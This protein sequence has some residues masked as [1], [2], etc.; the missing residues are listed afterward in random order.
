MYSFLSA[1]QKRWSVVMVM[2]VLAACTTIAPGMHF[3]SSSV[4][5]DQ[6]TQEVIAVNKPVMKAITPQLV[7]FEREQRD[8]QSLQDISQLVRGPTPYNIQGGDIL[9]ITVWDHPELAGTVT[10][11]PIQGVVGSENPGS[12]TPAT[13][14]V[15]DH[16]GIIQYPYAGSLKVAGMTEGQAKNALATKLGR[17]INKPNITLRVESYRSKRVYLDGEVKQPGLQPITDVPMTLTEAVNRAG[18]F[19]PTADQSQVA[20]TRDG[21]TYKVNLV[22]MMERGVNP[23]TI[24]LANGD[25]VRVLSRDE[26][27]VFVSGEVMQPKSLP[28]HN[29]RMTLN[30]ALGETGGINPQTGD[31]RQVYVVRNAADKDAT[32]YHL[33]TRSPAGLSLAEEFELKPK[34]VV[35]VDAAP[36]ATWHRVI[37]LILPAAL[38][39]A[40]SVGAATR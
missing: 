2:P 39:Q 12:A 32:V 20:V 25:V 15:V 16:E 19:L 24:M 10:S 13:G 1:H 9:A 37:S 38:S 26:S 8:K 5:A 3:D 22:Q 35:Y 34:D 31:G 18:G 14:F 28:M 4:T 11:V 7:K 30:E 29:G 40:V 23:G 33:D 27:K 17:Y 36:L 6:S 21:K